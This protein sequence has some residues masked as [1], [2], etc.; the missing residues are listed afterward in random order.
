[1]TRN[2]NAASEAADTRLDD[3]E[4]RRRI[5]DVAQQ[6]SRLEA[7]RRALEEVLSGLTAERD[8]LDRQVAR[9][10]REQGALEEQV[11]GERR[12][13]EELEAQ[14]EAVRREIP[15]L[16]QR[17]AEQL[18]RSDELVRQREAVRSEVAGLER[19]FAD[20]NV[21]LRGLR[22]SLSRIDDRLHREKK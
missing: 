2:E 13:T 18:E 7:D 12:R 5:R 14:I 11:A 15:E 22:D 19:A 21:E 4:L 6:V 17:C 20:S 1:M 8:A 10:E 16:E 3:V 9:G